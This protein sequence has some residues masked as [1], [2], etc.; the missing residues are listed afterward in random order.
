LSFA[1]TPAWHSTAIFF[2]RQA[3]F[4]EECSHAPRIVSLIASS[5][6]IVCAL[7]FEKDLA[8]ISH[9]CDFPP[10]I[11][12]LPVCTAPKFNLD[13]TSYD[14]DQRVKAIVQEGLSVY[15]VDGEKL[16]KLRP[17][18]IITRTQCEVCAVSQ[19]EVEAAVCAWLD[20]RPQIAALEPN[21]L[22]DVWA[23]MQR[24]ANA[25][26]APK[27]GEELISRLQKRMSGIAQKARS[28]SARPTVACIELRFYILKYFLS[29]M[30]AQAGKR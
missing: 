3:L 6:E 23:D 24:V 20:S 8:G 7:G 21:A 30:K 19:R 25:L 22:A 9:E 16:Q 10:T 5:T 14:L 12:G 4:Q 27:R 17:D 18:I 15:R 2:F 1:L 29:G 28:V 11:K 26:Q 13:G